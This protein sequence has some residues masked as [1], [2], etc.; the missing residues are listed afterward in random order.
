MGTLAATSRHLSLH[1]V[2]PSPNRIVLAGLSKGLIGGLWG[3]AILLGLIRR[4]SYR[5]QTVYLVAVAV[6]VVAAAAQWKI[7]STASTI[8][9][10]AE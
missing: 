7:F 4:D 1:E 5:A 6:A 10:R 3:G 2:W 8:E 9:T